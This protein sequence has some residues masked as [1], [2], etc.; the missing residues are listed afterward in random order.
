MI[1]DPD[2]LIRLKK[3]GL[4]VWNIVSRAIS[5]TQF[6][7]FAYGNIFCPFHE[8]K[9]KPSATFFI[10]QEDDID[11]LHCYTCH[12]QYTSYN[13]IKTFLKER[14]LD[15]LIKN[16]PEISIRAY[17]NDGIVL[18]TELMN[19]RKD[20]IDKIWNKSNNN[21]STFLGLLYT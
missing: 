8:D 2:L 16:I 20:Q 14:P 10:D 9:N 15:Y 6:V 21:I 11:R 5:I 4:I 13:Y 17:L 18:R 12:K 1:Q 7:E 19:D 3:D